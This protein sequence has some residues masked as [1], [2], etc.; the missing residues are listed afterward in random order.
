MTHTYPFSAYQ[1]KWRPRGCHFNLKDVDIIISFIRFQGQEISQ[2]ESFILNDYGVS[3]LC[4]QVNHYD[5]SLNDY[6]V[7]N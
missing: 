2:T 4:G 1:S 5:G 6:V 7:Q 3:N